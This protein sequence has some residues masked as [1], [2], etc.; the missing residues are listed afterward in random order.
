MR[1]LQYVDYRS[2]VLMIVDTVETRMALCRAYTPPRPD[3]PL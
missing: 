1:M 2:S 3:S